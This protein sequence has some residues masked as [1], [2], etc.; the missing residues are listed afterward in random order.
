MT[1]T[2]KPI[3]PQGPGIWLTDAEHRA[4]L[5][6]KEAA[7]RESVKML[8]EQEYANNRFTNALIKKH[9]EKLTEAKASAAAAWEALNYHASRNQTAAQ[10]MSDP[11]FKDATEALR[12]VKEAAWDEGYA[13]GCKL[14]IDHQSNPYAAKEAA[15]G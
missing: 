7:E 12:R 1:D 4:L 13:A 14:P 9:A 10:A 2:T 6:A 5:D 8:I 3:I 15:H 11:A